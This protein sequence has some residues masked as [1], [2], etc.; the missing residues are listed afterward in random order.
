MMLRRSALRPSGPQLGRGPTEI[1][2]R[3]TPLTPEGGSG[4]S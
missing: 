2:S 4:G 3:R 1:L